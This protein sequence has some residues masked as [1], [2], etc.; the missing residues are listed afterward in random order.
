[1]TTIAVP[2]KLDFNQDYQDVAE[3]DLLAFIQG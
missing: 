2:L 1:M 3:A